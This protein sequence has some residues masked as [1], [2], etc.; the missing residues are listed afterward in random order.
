METQLLERA[1]ETLPAIT[2]SITG[3]HTNGG[4]PGVAPAILHGILT[5]PTLEDVRNLLENEIRHQALRE[6]EPI[7][8]TRVDGDTMTVGMGTSQAV[9]LT[10]KPDGTVETQEPWAIHLLPGR[11]N[12]TA[13]SRPGPP[14]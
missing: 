3:K 10:K 6:L 11:R 5:E 14:P 4:P 9:T 8:L 12:T 13:S 1:R 2:Q 7:R